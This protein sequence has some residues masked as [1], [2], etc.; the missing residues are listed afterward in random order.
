MR[1]LLW[2]GVMIVCMG[3]IYYLNQAYRPDVSLENQV[4]T[5]SYSDEYGTEGD[6]DE[7]GTE[8]YSDEEIGFLSNRTYD[9][10]RVQVTASSF[11]DSYD[12]NS[13]RAKMLFDD[14]LIEITDYPLKVEIAPDG[15]GLIYLSN[16]YLSN[17]VYAK[18]GQSFIENAANIYST[19]NKTTLLCYSDQ[20]SI[21]NPVLVDCLFDNEKNAEWEADRV[22]KKASYERSLERLR[23]LE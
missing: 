22:A 7:F 17:G 6:S 19:D 20:F 13:I 10:P 18:G 16:P 1:N 4:D 5:E 14:K 12:S 8:S 23:N 2:I 3:A 11:Y 21:D 15:D 9:E